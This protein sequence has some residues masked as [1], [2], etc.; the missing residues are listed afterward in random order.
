MSGDATTTAVTAPAPAKKPARWGVRSIASLLI[1]IIAAAFTPIAL[2]GHW[3]Y[4]TVIDSER[5]IDTVG[6]LVQQPEV[7]AA[8]AESV[9]TAVV[10]KLD[11]QDQ[12]QGLLNNLFDNSTLTGAIAAPLATGINS[13]IGELVTKFIASPQFETVWVQLNKAAQKGLVAA[14]EGGD[15]GPVQIQGENVVL[16]VSSALT[17]IQQHLVDSGITV[18][19]NVTI[20][21]N[22]RQIVLMSSPALAQ[23]RF[24]YSLTSPVLQWF[25]L[26]IAALFALSIA[27]ARRRARTVVATG[28]VLVVSALVITF[29]LS[30]AQASFTDQMAGTPFGPAAGVF[31]D[32]LLAYLIAGIQAVLV[33]GI[34]VIV[35]GWFGGRT[36]LAVQARGHVTRGLTELG[37]RLPAGF[38]ALG[39]FFQQFQQY[40]RWAIYVV[41]VL[42]LMGVALLTSVSVLWC[43]ALA[44]GL[45]TLVQVLVGAAEPSVGDGAAAESSTTDSPSGGLTTIL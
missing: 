18:A 14:L 38:D 7:Q 1:F 29:G 11:T 36:Q 9:T 25:P 8:L 30:L 26:V 23:A 13:L 15:S 5:Y 22:D 42:I 39:A 4:R 27:L 17:A 43:V 45:V 3:G 2:V 12:V 34:A 21:D 10:A 31:W 41:V 20:P 19:G 35:A 16:D 33:L 44:A 32:T 40:I 28:I 24:I 37:Q 6:P